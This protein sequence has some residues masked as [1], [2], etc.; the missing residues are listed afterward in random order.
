MYGSCPR[1]LASLLVI[2]SAILARPPLAVSQSNLFNRPSD[3]LP[4][5]SAVPLHSPAT[6][7][8]NF[9][10]PSLPR[11]APSPVGPTPIR[12]P[13]LAHTAGTIF[14][15]TVTAIA[16]QPAAHGQAIETVAITFHVEEAIRGATPGDNLTITQWMGVWSSGQR[17]CVGE[18]VLLF[19][20]PPSKL[21]LTSVVGG[22]L[23]RF[24]VDPVG[25]VRLTQQHLSAFQEDPVLG[26]KP[27]L[28]VR[29]FT[30]AVQ[31]ISEE[32]A[33]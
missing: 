3:K 6:P 28:S 9:M 30:A 32:K 31:R 14:S 29:D 33:Q 26:G 8:A 22:P 15:G 1:L 2:S 21:G 25:R 13:L 10:Q 19:L 16:H 27:S 11:A 7:A 23:G 5:N 12:F 20:Y 18:R 4:E 24:T 17:Y